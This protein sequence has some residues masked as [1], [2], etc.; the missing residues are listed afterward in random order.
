MTISIKDIKAIVNV[1]LKDI[2]DAR[3][4]AIKNG[5]IE[6]VKDCE[7][8][9]IQILKNA[10]S[11]IMS[12]ED[13]SM[14]AKINYI[15]DVCTLCANYIDVEKVFAIRDDAVR[16]F[17]IEY[18]IE[19][20]AEASDANEESEEATAGFDEVEES[21]TDETVNESD[22]NNEESAE[23]TNKPD[24]EESDTKDET[25]NKSDETKES[26]NEVFTEED[27]TDEENRK[28]EAWEDA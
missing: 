20:R 18:K 26:N 17:M 13:K 8:K 15:V 11:E 7:S 2:R 12:I 28:H 16:A 21:D 1:E 19:R 24:A 25:V 5:S 27:Y 22:I 10:I 4:F 9:A 6:S 3:K 23:S 14:Q